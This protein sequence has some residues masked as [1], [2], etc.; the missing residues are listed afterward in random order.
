MSVIADQT[1]FK[2]NHRVIQGLH[3]HT[4]NVLRAKEFKI[5]KSILESLF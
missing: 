1:T 5:L 3:Y 2:N 4:I